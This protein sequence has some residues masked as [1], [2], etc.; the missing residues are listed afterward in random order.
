[1]KPAVVQVDPE[2]HTVDRLQSLLAGRGRAERVGTD[3]PSDWTPGSPMFVQVAHDGTPTLDW[4]VRTVSTMRV[5]VWSRI[6]SDGR[7]LAVLSMGLLLAEPGYRESTGLLLTVDPST[8]GRLASF[9]V[10][11]SQMTAPL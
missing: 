3:L 7:N 2:R 4:P 1:V 10:L 6:K 11:L 8:R 5:T 9:A